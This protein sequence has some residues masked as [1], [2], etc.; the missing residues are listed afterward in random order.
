[1]EIG[2]MGHRIILLPQ[3]ALHFP[4]DKILVISDLHF[5]KVN[6]FRRSGI[7]VPLKANDT[8]TE[9]LIE[10]FNKIKPERVIFLGDL[11]HSHYNDEWEVIG[12]VIKHFRSVSFELVQ[13]NHDIMSQHQYE[14]HRLKVHDE[15]LIGSILL[16]HEPMKEV[17]EGRFN[18]AGHIHPGVRL[19]GRGRQAL[20][21]PCFYFGKTMGLM[22]AFGAFT[23]F[24]PIQVKKE[25]RVFVIADGK[26]IKVSDDE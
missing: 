20:T 26:I 15:L 12:Q 21:L 25:D 3:K 8:N 13:G 5:G 14:R 2:L 11:F 24:V 18:L 1:M 16:T 9:T 19:S 10:L 23:G 6:H 17:A 7:P 4:D 22:P